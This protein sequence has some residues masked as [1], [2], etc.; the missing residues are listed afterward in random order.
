M[1]TDTRKPTET[2]AGIGETMK[3]AF[4]RSLKVAGETREFHRDNAEAL[5]EASRHSAEGIALVGQSTG[6]Y[7]AHSLERAKNVFGQLLSAK[8]P[9][10]FIKVH[11]DYMKA[12][13][14][15]AAAHNAK[16]AQILTQVASDATKPLTARVASVADKATR[17]S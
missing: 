11:G 7:L 15:A 3:A 10:D 2:V 17:K 9:S 1:N 12:S 4:E 14:E 13:V 6:E 5:A 16:V 8:T